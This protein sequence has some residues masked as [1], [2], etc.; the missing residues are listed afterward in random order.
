MT[1]L[2]EALGGTAAADVRVARIDLGNELLYAALLPIE[3]RAEVHHYL[4]E[5][6]DLS[7]PL[8]GCAL[9]LT[10]DQALKVMGVAYGAK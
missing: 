6:T 3:Y 10:S 4:A 7:M 1:L 2:V 5:R 9:I 8:D